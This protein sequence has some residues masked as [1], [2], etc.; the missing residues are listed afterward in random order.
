MSKTSHAAESFFDAKFYQ[1]V[2]LE[3]YH[4]HAVAST[5]R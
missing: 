2:P 1:A 3:M 4:Y 5:H